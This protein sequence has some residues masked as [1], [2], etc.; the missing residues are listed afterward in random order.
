MHASSPPVSLIET[1]SAIAE[2]YDAVICDVWGVLHNG[3]RVTR[4]ANEALN[5]M[6]ARGM[7]V[8]MLTNAPRPPA[9]IEAFVRQLGAQGQVWDAVV[10]SGG[11]TRSI[12][13]G[14]GARPFHHMGPARDVSVY[15]GLAARKVALGEA[16]YV[17]CTG[18]VDD[19]TETAEDYRPQLEAMLTRRIELICANPDIVVERGHKLV[20]C[21]GAIAELYEQMGGPV[22]WVGKPHPLVYDYALGEIEKAL[23]RPVERARILGIGDAI[24]TDVAGAKGYGIESLFILDGIHGRE[25]GLKDGSVDRQAFSGFLA[26]QTVQPRWAMPVLTF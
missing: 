24:R 19:E 25:A 10:S 2:R 12:M 3:V 21:A 11:V 23:S 9:D 17:L 22:T 15:E 1:F 4:Q 16:D 26:R 13:A 8:V 18:L 5:A 20:P 6:R 7:A 14:H